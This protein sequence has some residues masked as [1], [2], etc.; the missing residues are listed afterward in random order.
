M[1]LVELGFERQNA[2]HEVDGFANRRDARLPPRPDLRAHVLH[3]LES[4][5]LQ[6]RRSGTIEIL[7]VDADERVDVALLDARDQLAAQRED[8]PQVRQHLEEAHDGDLLGAIPRLAAG[9]DHLRPRH[10][11]E[12]CVW[13]LRLERLDEPRAERIARRLARHQRKS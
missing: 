11:D 7:R 12:L 1:R 6:R 13:R 3:G 9:R 8:A 4:R 10:A 2:E 5:A